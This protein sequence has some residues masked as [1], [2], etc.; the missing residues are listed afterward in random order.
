MNVAKI[1]GFYEQVTHASLV[2]ENLIKKKLLLLWL[3]F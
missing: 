1:T 3:L 2:I